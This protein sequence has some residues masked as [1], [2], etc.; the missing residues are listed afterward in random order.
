MMMT[1]ANAGLIRLIKKR[2]VGKNEV[3]ANKLRYEFAQK[4]HLNEQR[5][6]IAPLFD[7]RPVT[8]RSITSVRRQRV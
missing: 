7:N 6:L 3:V 4:M 2:R 8:V 5:R 1:S